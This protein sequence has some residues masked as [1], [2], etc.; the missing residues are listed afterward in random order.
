MFLTFSS[1][2]WNDNGIFCDSQKCVYIHVHV[3][4]VIEGQVH[5]LFLDYVM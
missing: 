5:F 3:T 1:F 2:K 4:L